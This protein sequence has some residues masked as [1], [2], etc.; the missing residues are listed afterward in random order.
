MAL[1]VTISGGA[2]IDQG[3]Q[4][5]LAAV[6]VDANGN[7]P[8]GTLQYVWTAS[9]GSFIGD[10]TG[11]AVVYEADFTD[12]TNVIVMITCAV[13]RAADA[14]PTV[15]GG[16]LTAM[17]ELGITGQ[18]LNMFINPTMDTL[19]DQRVDI[20]T[21]PNGLA[22]GSDD[23]IAANTQITR[24]EWRDDNNDLFLRRTGSG[25]LADYWTSNTGK[26]LYLIFQDGVVYQL[27]TPGQSGLAWSRWDI[28]DTTQQAKLLAIDA[29]DMLLVGIADANTI[30]LAEDTGTGNASFIAAA[31]PVEY[32]S[33]QQLSELVSAEFGRAEIAVGVQDSDDALETI[34][35]RAGAAILARFLENLGA[36]DKLDYDTALRNLPTI[37]ALRDA[38][39]TYALIQSLLNYNDL[40][41]RPTIPAA[42][43]NADWDAVSGLAQILNKPTIPIDTTLWKGNYA[44][45]TAYGAG[46]IVIHNGMVILFKSAVADTNTE[47]NPLDITGAEQLDIGSPNDL[48][49]VT[50]TQSTKVLSLFKRDGLSIDNTLSFQTQTE[51]DALY[52]ALNHNHDS[53]YAGLSH[54]HDSRYYQES[55]VDTLLGNKSDTTHTHDGRYYQESEVDTLLGGKSDS[56]HTH[57]GRYFTETEMNNLLAGKSDTGHTHDD[58]YFTETEVTTALA[59]KANTNHGTHLTDATLIAAL[60]GL[61]SDEEEDAREALQIYVEEDWN[62]TITL[63]G[64]VNTSNVDFTSAQIFSIGNLVYTILDIS[65]S[66]TPMQ[67]GHFRSID[68]PTNFTIPASNND[69]HW[70]YHNTGTRFVA[71]ERIDNNTFRFNAQNISVGN[72]TLIMIWRK[73]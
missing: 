44:V 13:T 8:A 41:N 52:A 67:P 64:T 63:S 51:A 27:G 45:S 65:V 38:A 62:P 48:V 49:A 1:T 73:G 19:E 37:P 57:D 35:R 4:R 11:A 50:F 56:G 31:P 25:S 54:E 72:Q 10:T 40:Q 26:G 42:Q 69:L 23:L 33:F 47:T 58:R 28:D 14:T 3:Q 20:Y 34:A 55:E 43:V 2:D 17:H 5:N 22:V 66:A 32:G 12:E 6:V 9:R 21:A 70:V 29:N 59:G 7:T 61:D 71:I 46:T 18:D 16:S 39:A 36:S 24:I 68:L 60:Q 15:A 30:G 53:A